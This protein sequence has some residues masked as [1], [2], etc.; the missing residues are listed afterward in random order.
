MSH[1]EGSSL[2][3]LYLEA[4]DA[5]RRSEDGIRKDG[6]R[7]KELYCV[8]FRLTQP[9]RGILA[10]AG[11]PYNPAFA[12]AEVLW[13]LAGDTGDWLCRYNKKYAAYFKEGRLSGGY[14][15]RLMNWPGEEG[16]VNQLDRAVRLLKESPHSQHANLII[17]DP[18]ADL[19]EPQP[20]FVPCIT[21]V[22]LRVR[23]GRLHFSS[24]LRAQDIWLGFPYDVFLLLNLFQQLAIELGLEMGDYHHFCDV[25]RL[26]EPNFEEA[27]RVCTAMAPDRSRSIDL[28]HGPAEIRERITWYRDL[29][30]ETP[31]DLEN[32][33]NAQPPYWRDCLLSCHAYAQLRKG[34]VDEA[35]RVIATI[36]NVFREQF[37]V[38]AGRYWPALHA[39]LS[40]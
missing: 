3:D 27:E 34:N 4:L 30:R 22:K 11:R 14:G 20:K 19:V 13:N 39:A 29:I 33:A 25:L 37:R 26:Y 24:F 40:R 32:L 38:W 36:G 28:A 15:A 1:F 31:P 12:V 9:R 8:T 35:A 5:V 2:D 21:M 7:I 10:I 6:R 17:F 18:S 16:R 23:Q